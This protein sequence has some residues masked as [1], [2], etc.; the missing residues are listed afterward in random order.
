VAGGIQ[1][2]ER[3]TVLRAGPSSATFVSTAEWLCSD[4]C[5]GLAGN[6]VVYRDEH[7]VT[8]TISRL[9]VDRMRAAVVRA[10]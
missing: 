6:V 2:T 7:H 3:A 9:L 5:A 1:A 4:V 10:L 8:A